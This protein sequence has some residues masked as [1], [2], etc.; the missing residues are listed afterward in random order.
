MAIDYP[1]ILNTGRMGELLCW[2]SREAILYALG[3]GM[4]IDEAELGF[5]Y[6][7]SLKAVPTQAT[8]VAW[9]A[10]PRI[11]QLGLDYARVLHGE[12]EVLLHRP[13]PAAGEFIADTSVPA[14]FD[15][16]RDKGA[17]VI[18][19]TVLRSAI[20]ALPIATVRKTLFARGD[21]G[22]GGPSEGAPVPHSVPGRPADRVL[23]MATRLDQAALYRLCGD[24]NPLHI[25][26]EAARAA[27]FAEPILHGLCTFGM[28]C[29]AVLTVYCD[30]DPT[31][32]VSHSARFAAPV[33]PGDMLEVLLWRDGHTVS[34]EMS[35][36]ARSV[37]VIKNGKAVLS[38]VQRDSSRQV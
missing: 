18:R 37:K 15:K 20:D 23:Q 31:R 10:G 1:G 7:K 9:G 16:G 35:V 26:P 4:G 30:G 22:F 3:I 11:Q 36:A 2:T 25:D 19:Q 24:L 27:G 5:V 14:V 8:A 33:Y 17:I 34:F 6:E 38:A 28:S 29:R 12:E 13:M 32:L 21:G